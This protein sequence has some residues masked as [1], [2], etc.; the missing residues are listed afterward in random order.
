MLRSRR[1]P[2]LG[3]RAR[4]STATRATRR[5]HG[6]LVAAEVA[7]AVLLMVA[8]SLLIRSVGALM[9]E[10]PGFEL[11]RLLTAEVLVPQ[12]VQ[13]ERAG[14]LRTRRHGPATSRPWASRCSRV[15]ASLGKNTLHRYEAE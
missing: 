1:K 14:V 7:L 4:G 6:F 9:A 12:E 5:A 11:E 13:P 3:S 10:E 2:G 15:A 8:A